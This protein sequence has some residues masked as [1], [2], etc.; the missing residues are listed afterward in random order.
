MKTRASLPGPSALWASAALLSACAGPAA[1]KAADSAGPTVTLDAMPAPDDWSVRGPGGPTGAFSEDELLQPCA[2]LNGGEGSAEHHNLV[3]MHDGYLLFPWA[4]EDGGGGISFFDVSDP[5]DPVKVG[6]TWADTMRESHTLATGRVGDREYLAVDHHVSGTQGGIGFFDITDPAAPTW[7]GSLDL[8]GYAYPDAYFRVALSATWLG[9]RLFVPA[10]LLGV[11]TIDV[12]DPTNPV[13]LDQVVETGHIVG[14]FHVVGD[15]AVASSAGLARVITYDVSDPAAWQVRTDFNLSTPDEAQ[16]NFYF[17]NIGGRYALFARKNN[18]GGPVALDLTD[19][20][21]PTLAGTFKTPEGEGGYVFRQHDRLFQGEGGYGAIF[22]FSDPTAITQLARVDLEG[23][24][25]TVTPLGNVLY[26]SVDEKGDPGMATAVFPWAT[27]P[28]TR[29]PALDWHR[30]ADG[31]TWVAPT[32]AIG[33]SF[34]EMIEPRSAHTG[35]FRVWTEDGTAVPGRFYPMEAVVNFVPDAPLPA[36][37]TIW[38]EVPAGGVADPSG[39][40]TTEAV[41]FAFST[42]A[43]VTPWPA[44]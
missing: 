21:A 35:S 41:R 11:F 10:G 39:N 31:Q 22:D 43:E 37:T 8:P 32:S 16:A 24:L 6:E 9:D 44:P 12:S 7:V 27:D 3:V 1:D 13:I 34:D 26:A 25:D 33:L 2:Y 30:P 18:G 19:P 14:T 29:G 15:V 17:A 28:D 23:D 38:V 4:P 5:C 40:P 36:D 20:D 42:G